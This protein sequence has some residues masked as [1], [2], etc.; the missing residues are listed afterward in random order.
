M[1]DKNYD[2]NARYDM[3]PSA[4]GCGRA[5]IQSELAST[6]AKGLQPDGTLKNAPLRAGQHVAGAPRDNIG[7]NVAG[8]ARSING[9]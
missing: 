8:A 2:P 9:T 1:A 5:S 4:A 6:R 3:G 7:P